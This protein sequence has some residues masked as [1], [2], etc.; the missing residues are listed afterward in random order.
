MPIIARLTPVQKARQKRR[1][2]RVP[3]NVNGKTIEGLNQAMES[4]VTADLLGGLTKFRGD[5]LKIELDKSFNAQDYAALK[6]TVGWQAADKGIQAASDK[7]TAMVPQT[8]Q[9]VRQGIAGGISGDAASDASFFGPMDFEHAF[10]P[11]AGP[12]DAK[13]FEPDPQRALRRRTDATN[14]AFGEVQQERIT[15]AKGEQKKAYLSDMVLPKR[16]EVQRI[17]REGA[18]QGLTSQEI[19]QNLSN[20]VGLREDQKAA[21]TKFKQGLVADVNTRGNKIPGLVAAKSRELLAQRCEMIA[22]TEARAASGYAQLASAL[23]MQEQ[24]LLGPKTV[25]IWQLGW[26]KACPNICRPADGQRRL[27]SEKFDLGGKRKADWGGQAH[28]NCRCSCSIF[29]P[30]VDDGPQG[31]DLGAFETEAEIDDDDQ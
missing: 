2:A 24:G 11:G 30:D 26:E 31:R 18:A 6:E 15:N 20:V 14:P 25:K 22:V 29:D 13:P 9:A 3:V 23:A 5:V 1:V 10:G 8:A 19:A 27:L 21:L 17:V 4:A 7:L 16:Q 28:P 12:A